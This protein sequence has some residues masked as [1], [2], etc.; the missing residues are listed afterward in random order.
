[1]LNIIEVARNTCT[2]ADLV[3]ERYGLT[4]TE[5]E[6]LHLLATGYRVPEIADAL[7][8]ANGTI[9]N[10]LSLIYTKIGVQNQI[11]LMTMLHRIAASLTPNPA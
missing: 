7:F 6:M 2:A 5:R 11:Q 10:R 4:E 1:M 9:R 8:L 3:G